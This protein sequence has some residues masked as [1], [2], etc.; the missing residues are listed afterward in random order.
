VILAEAV[1]FA[2]DMA[3]EPSNHLTPTELAARALQA[4]DEAG[5]ECTVLDQEDMVELGMGGLLG[6]AQG[7]HQHPKFII[8]HYRGV[9]ATESAIGFV[10]KGITFDTGGISIK[11]AAGME[12]MKGDM[13]GGAAVIAALRALGRLKPRINVTGIVPATENMPGGGAI[14]PG[15]VLRAMNGKTIEVVNTDAEGRLILADG[16]SYAQR[17]GLSP[18][19]DVATLTGAMGVALGDK[20]FGAMT[21]DQATVDRVIAAATRAGEKAW[22]MPMFEEYKEQIKSE[23][24]DMKNSGGRP[25][26]S[27]TAAMLLR[28]F[29]GD[30]PWVHLD[31]AGVDFYT[32]EK[33]VTVKGASG[34]PV[35]TLVNVA[36]GYADDGAAP[37]K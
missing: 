1:N 32:S 20:A 10:G 16:L 9:P 13:S 7:S 25:A 21:N 19:I 4:A 6:V 3:N 28:E 35:R 37:A 8:L 15:D 24:A 2:R 22:Q 14:K 30:T 17:L 33:G 26:G 31:I 34:I 23:V 27:I 12:E 18:I 36:L 11:P 5:L 29:V